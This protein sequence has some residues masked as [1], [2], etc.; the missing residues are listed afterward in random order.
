MVGYPIRSQ[1]KGLWSYTAMEVHAGISRGAMGLK[2][3]IKVLETMYT[4]KCC[5]CALRENERI[6]AVIHRQKFHP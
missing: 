2:Q 4:H 5:D 6:F 1:G 3:K